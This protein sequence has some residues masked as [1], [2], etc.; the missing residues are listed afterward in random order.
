MCVCVFCVTLFLEALH[1]MMRMKF[2]YAV[3]KVREVD[4]EV[5]YINMESL[6]H[7]LIK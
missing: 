4:E 3:K 7:K 6:H 1:I 2:L 5:Y